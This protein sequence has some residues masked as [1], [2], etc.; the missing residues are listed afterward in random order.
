MKMW[1][2][3]AQFEADLACQI[4]SRPGFSS[5]LFWLTMVRHINI[6]E[7]GWLLYRPTFSLS[8]NIFLCTGISFVF[9][10]HFKIFIFLEFYPMQILFV[11]IILLD[12]FKIQTGKPVQSSLNIIIRSLKVMRFEVFGLWLLV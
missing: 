8:Q 6:R 5:P 9:L 7:A 4:W 3:A 1:A 10:R 11:Y 2:L 12:Y